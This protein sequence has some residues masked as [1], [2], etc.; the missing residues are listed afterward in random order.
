MQVETILLRLLLS[1]LLGSLIGFER[2]YRSKS[3]GLRTLMLISLGA[4]IFTMMS[5]LIGTPGS[6][7]R[8]ASNIVTGI[9]FVGGGVIF[10]SESRMTGITTAATIWITAAI[11]MATGGGYYFTAICGSALI[12]VVLLLFHLIERLVDNVSM[13]RH[14]TISCAYKQETTS[15]IEALFIQ[16]KLKLRSKRY[17]RKHET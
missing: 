12:L 5:T 1:V 9:G 7:D 8:I 6:P 10:K 15:Q 14:Y 17:V 2:E 3:A 16:Y 11:G 13:M 4:S